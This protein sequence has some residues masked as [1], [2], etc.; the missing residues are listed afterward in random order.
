MQPIFH[1]RQWPSDLFKLLPNR[2]IPHYSA[3]RYSTA[4]YTNYTTPQLQLQLHYTNYTT[5]QLPLHYNYNYNCITPHYIQQLWWGDPCNHCNH[6]KKHNSNHLSVHQW[7]HS[8]I[9][10][11]QQPTSPIVSY[12]WNFRHRLVRYFSFF[13]IQ[14]DSK[15][16]QSILDR[17]KTEVRQPTNLV[18]R[19]P[20]QISA[21]FQH[22]VTWLLQM[23]Y[24]IT[25]RPELL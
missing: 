22:M 8:A 11:S 13:I 1:L 2:T 5:L 18:L 21:G 25:W 17:D 16:N 10:D 19:N 24:A 12:V 14:H 7:I 15:T 9:C 4:R 3:Q 23:I 6:S 20:H